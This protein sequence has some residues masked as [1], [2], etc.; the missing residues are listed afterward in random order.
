MSLILE[1]K[2]GRLAGKQIAV[3]EGREVTIGRA[4]DRADFGVPHDNFMSSVHFAVECGRE[5]C[6][7]R[8]RKSSNGTFLNGARITEAALS[9]GDEIR[10][11]RTA[12]AVRIIAEVP[13]HAP[14]KPAAAPPPPPPAPPAPEPVPAAPPEPPVVVAP[15]PAPKEPEPAMESEPA[16]APLPPPE[17][18]VAAP[19]VEPPAPPV[20]EKPAVSAKPAPA[21]PAAPPPPGRPLFTIGSWSFTRVPKGWDAQGE[22]GIQR[23][24][25]DAFPSNVVPG[26][27]MLGLA[28]LQ[29][30][31]EAQVSMLRKYLREPQIEAS[32]PPAIHGAE[33]TVALDIRY[34]TKDDQ[35]IVLRRIFARQ[36]Q[37][38]GVLTLT[39]LEK[40]LEEI[41]PALDAIL[42]GASFQPKD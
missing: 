13:E 27:E 5:G 17:P 8:D 25:K 19:P 34:A 24:E 10:S 41:L 42:A 4:P 36:A 33:E 35:V 14:A 37:R 16:P 9:D 11:G 18:V 21:R 29:R 38:V 26:E 15:P 39:T 40:D 31:V 2:A 28:T 22:F 20:P 23:A 7:V 6:R 3:L 12:F 1:V 30:F 32:L